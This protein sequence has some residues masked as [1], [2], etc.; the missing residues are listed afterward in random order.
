MFLACTRVSI[1]S[2]DITLNCA[3]KK[4]SQ[5]SYQIERIFLFFNYDFKWIVPNNLRISMAR[6]SLNL[7][8]KILNFLSLR[9]KIYL[10]LIIRINRNLA[11]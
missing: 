5:N 11:T 1:I 10:F 8:E 4:C 6:I 7:E 9:I 3:R 2:Q